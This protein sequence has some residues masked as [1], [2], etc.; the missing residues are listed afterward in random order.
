ME[1]Y[2]RSSD[3]TGH[4][5]QYE[6]SSQYGK[7]S[8][9]R[10]S[11]LRRR[12]GLHPDSTSQPDKQIRHEMVLHIRELWGELRI[13]GHE[14]LQIAERVEAKIREYGIENQ[15]GTNA[16]EQVIDRKKC[17]CQIF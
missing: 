13:I 10:L 4:S 9:D 14:E 2:T 7:S 17:E 12:H 16:L 3:A 5:T 11:N 6:R 8:Q 1:Q 15:D